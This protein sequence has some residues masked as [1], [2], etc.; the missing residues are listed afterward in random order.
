MARRRRG[1]GRPRGSITTGARGT[2]PVQF[3]LGAAERAAL[4]A[5]G[6]KRG[7]SG[8]VEA[9]RIVLEALSTNSPSGSQ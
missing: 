2:A 3:R 9:K 8:D 7:V 5:R 4:D 1:P 6:E